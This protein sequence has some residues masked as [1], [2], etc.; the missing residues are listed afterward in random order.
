M[1]LIVF[2]HLRFLPKLEST[3]SWSLKVHWKM[4]LFRWGNRQDPVPPNT[5]SAFNVQVLFVL[6]L[7][8]R[9]VL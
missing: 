3:N 6:D 7:T 5:L 2:S 4:C 1:K 8:V 9:T